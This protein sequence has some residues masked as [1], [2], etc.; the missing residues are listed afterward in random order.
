MRAMPQKRAPW[1]WVRWAT[2]L[3]WQ[4]RRPRGSYAELAL[5][6]EACARRALPTRPAPGMC[7][8]TGAG[9][10]GSVRPTGRG[11]GD[12]GVGYEGT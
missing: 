10:G 7:L 2:R 1:T 6:F 8:S 11:G 5:D 3:R 12:G 9:A 4:E